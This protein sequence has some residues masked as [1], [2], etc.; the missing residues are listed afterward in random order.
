M[1]P[2]NRLFGL[3][4]SRDIRSIRGH[5]RFGRPVLSRHTVPSM[6]VKKPGH[7][8]GWKYYE[9]VS[10]GKEGKPVL[11][12]LIDLSNKSFSV[13]WLPRSYLRFQFLPL[14]IWELNSP[15]RWL[16]SLVLIVV[17]VQLRHRSVLHQQQDLTSEGSRV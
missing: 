2:V 5:R 8:P 17:L 3:L 11:S 4:S 15:R 9:R 1:H 10:W 16:A 7:K 12:T 13:I 14:L 6:D